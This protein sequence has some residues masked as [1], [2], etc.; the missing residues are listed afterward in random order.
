MSYKIEQRGP[1]TFVIDDAGKEH[2]RY[3]SRAAAVQAIEDIGRRPPPAVPAAGPVKGKTR[4]SIY[5]EARRPKTLLNLFKQHFLPRRKGDIL[6]ATERSYFRL[7]IWGG[8]DP[9]I[10]EKHYRNSMRVVKRLAASKMGN[11]GKR[12]RANER[13][14]K[15]LALIAQG[16]KTQKEI[17]AEIGITDRGLRKLLK[18]EK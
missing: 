6:R 1:E 7:E 9:A 16:G 5:R 10:V 3:P 14:A 15:A 17:A 4:S 13:L 12:K 11:A 2:G 18:R 8:T